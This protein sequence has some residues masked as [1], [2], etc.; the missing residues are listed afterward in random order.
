MSVLYTY[1]VNHGN[2]TPR[3]GAGTLI[4]GGRLET[5]MFADGLIRLEELE[6]FIKKI[7]NIAKDGS[8]IACE[9]DDFIY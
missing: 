3:V 1:V 5:V 6:E 4:N 9:I 2:E 8:R 7:R